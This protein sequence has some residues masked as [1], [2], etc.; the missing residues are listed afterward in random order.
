MMFYFYFFFYILNFFFLPMIASWR[1]VA[2]T[3]S[4][5]GLTS[6]LALC[7][8]GVIVS[9]NQQHAEIY[10]IVMISEIEDN[11]VQLLEVDI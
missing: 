4:L 2:L 3:Q 1:G 7:R 5:A 10:T 11:V 8:V 6:G 9:S